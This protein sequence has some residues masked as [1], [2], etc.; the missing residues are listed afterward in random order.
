MASCNTPTWPRQPGSL[1]CV[2]A[3]VTAVLHLS[4]VWNRPRCPEKPLDQLRQ[5]L[6]VKIAGPL[7][8]PISPDPAS[9]NLSALSTWGRK[10]HHRWRRNTAGALTTLKRR[11]SCLCCW[12]TVDIPLPGLC[13]VSCS[14]RVRAGAVKLLFF[15]L[16]RDEN[17]ELVNFSS[18]AG[19]R[20][21]CGCWSRFK[22]LW[23]FVKAKLNLNETRPNSTN[24]HTSTWWSRDA[25][26]V[27]HTLSSAAVSQKVSCSFISYNWWLRFLLHPSASAHHSSDASFPPCSAS[28]SQSW[29]KQKVEISLSLFSQTNTIERE[30]AGIIDNAQTDFT[31]LEWNAALFANVTWTHLH[32]KSTRCSVSGS[33]A[34]NLF[35]TH[36]NNW[37]IKACTHVNPTKSDWTQ[38]FGSSTLR[39]TFT[40]V[41]L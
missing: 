19:S 17:D 34:P 13:T 3:D 18:R 21:R 27:I 36:C 28:L 40:C 32:N 29:R 22:T 7:Q 38:L 14:G 1:G 5:G 30:M 12:G 41:K 10:W 23:L 35:V 37:V 26:L 15:R 6:P 25:V 20:S 9:W 11:S 31:C 8:G 24:L 16:Y 4:C 2:V 33:V 39:L